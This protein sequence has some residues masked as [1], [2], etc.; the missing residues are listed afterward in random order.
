MALATQI[1][2]PTFKDIISVVI[3]WVAGL[4]GPIAIPFMLG[5]LRRFRRSGPT[6]ALTSWA[7][8]LLA[9][10]LTNYNFDGSVK[11]DVALQ[12]QVALPLAISLVLYIVIGYIKPE[13]TPERDALIDRINSDDGSPAGGAAAAAVPAQRPGPES[14]GVPEGVK[15]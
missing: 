15:D 3:K 11:T 13:D 4:M 1:N 12:Y 8:G 2:S 7:A 5:L 6:A 14:T 9:F 10:Y